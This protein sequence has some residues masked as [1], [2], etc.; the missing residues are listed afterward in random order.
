MRP[1]ADAEP[2]PKLLVSHP[3]GLN[4]AENRDAE[5]LRHHDSEIGCLDLLARALKKRFSG[6]VE[7]EEPVVHFEFVVDRNGTID[8]D[9]FCILPEQRLPAGVLGGSFMAEQPGID[10]QDC[11]VVLDEP[12]VPRLGHSSLQRGNEAAT[13][14]RPH[15]QSGLHQLTISLLDRPQAVGKH[16][17]EFRFSRKLHAGSPVA[18]GDRSDDRG[19][20][21]LVF[22]SSRRLR[23]EAR[24]NG[25]DHLCVQSRRPCSTDPPH[26]TLIPVSSM[27]FAYLADS[28]RMNSRNSTGVLPTASAACA[29]KASRIC[30]SCNAATQTLAN[31]SSTACEVPVRPSRPNQLVKSKSSN[32]LVSAMAGMLGKAGERRLLATAMALSVPACRN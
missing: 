5:F 7:G 16:L 13:S 32:P 30:E 23:G 15:N 26:L 9:D 10:R 24:P 11:P 20:E 2:L 22:G 8:P 21:Q 3:D 12:A 19:A 14:A 25:F 28:A 17:R 29:L 18:T 6:A 27:T 31:L 1:R 4:D